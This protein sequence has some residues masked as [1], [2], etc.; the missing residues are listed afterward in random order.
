[1]K[2]F[3]AFFIVLLFILRQDYWWWDD[4]T[5]VCGFLPI[6]L[7]WQIAI[8]IAAGLGWWLATKFCWPKAL[9]ETF[10]EAEAEQ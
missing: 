8:T 4:K 9:E 6:G 3:I 7:A 10:P 1:V 2:F 5:V